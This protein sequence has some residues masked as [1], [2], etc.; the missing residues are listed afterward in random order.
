[1]SDKDAFGQVPN[2]I[3][4]LLRRWDVQRRQSATRRIAVASVGLIAGTL[5]A[6]RADDLVTQL[7][8]ATAGIACAAV[9]LIAPRSESVK[10]SRAWEVLH[11]AVSRYQDGSANR[12]DLLIAAAR[13]E[14]II[15]AADDP[16]ADAANARW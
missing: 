5:A 13:A 11:H 14:A 10:L 9:G 12:A 2:H 4:N 3:P 8:S 1:M 6:S 16:A 7:L 15:G